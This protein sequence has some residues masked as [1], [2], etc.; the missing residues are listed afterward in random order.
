MEGSGIPCLSFLVGMFLLSEITAAIVLVENDKQALLHFV[1]KLPHFHPFNWDANSA[2]CKNWT[3]I[4][5]SE[6]G[7][8]V[9]TL[10]LPGAGF[11]GPIP[12]NTLSP[13]T[14]L[15]ILSL[16]SNGI[17]DTFPMDF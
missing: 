17:N 1:N 3:A 16:R 6:D 10:R 2:I 9:I 4:T 8:R 14:A 13:L 15:Q 5:C 12:D 11:N 7:F